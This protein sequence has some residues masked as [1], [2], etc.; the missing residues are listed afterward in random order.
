MTELDILNILLE[1]FNKI[2]RIEFKP[3]LKNKTTTYK[4]IVQY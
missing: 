1:N 4:F 3:N 2:V